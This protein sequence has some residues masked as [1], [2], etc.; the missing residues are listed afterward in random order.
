MYS[1]PKKRTGPSWLYFGCR[2]ADADFIYKEE[3]DGALERGVLTQLRTAFSREQAAKVYVQHKLRE[4]GPEMWRLLGD[5]KGHLYIC[6]GTQ[7]GRD[8]SYLR[9]L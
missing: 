5:L 2:R 8:V 7:M 9:L 4:D 6:G 3:L 1:G